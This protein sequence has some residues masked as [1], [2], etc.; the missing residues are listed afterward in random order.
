MAGPFITA[1]PVFNEV[2]HVNR[3]LDEVIRYSDDVLVVNDGSTDGTTEVLARRN[4]IDLIHHNRNRGYGAAL[5]S[6]FSYAIAHGYEGIVT[7]DCDGQHEPQRIPMFFRQLTA[8]GADIISGSRYLRQFDGDSLPPEQRRAINETIT[9]ELNAKLDLQLTDTFCGF[10]AYRVSA[11]RDLRLTEDGYA[12]PLELWVQAA[13]LKLKIEETP[14][15]L[16]YLDEKRSFGGALDDGATRL[17]Y[18][19]EIIQRSMNSLPSDCNQR[20]RAGW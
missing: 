17:A 10:K 14:V 8:D 6:A 18:Y 16:I 4:D 12:M 2:K 15:P 7:I 13:C 11:L 1:L 19:R 5:R 3:V 9:A 20:V